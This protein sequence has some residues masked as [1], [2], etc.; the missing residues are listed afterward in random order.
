MLPLLDDATKSLKDII[1]GSDEKNKEVIDKI[2]KHI[3]N[4]IDEL[5]KNCNN[6]QS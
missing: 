6:K 3:D 2:I 5:S 1:K 4:K